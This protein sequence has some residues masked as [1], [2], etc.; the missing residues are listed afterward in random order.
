M[1]VLK[2]ITKPDITTLSLHVFPNNVSNQHFR[3]YIGSCLPFPRGSNLHGVILMQALTQYWTPLNSLE[4]TAAHSLPT[5]PHGLTQ[6]TSVMLGEHGTPPSGYTRTRRWPMKCSHVLTKFGS[7]LQTFFSWG[8]CKYSLVVSRTMLM[9]LG[10]LQGTLRPMWRFN[11]W[12][13]M[14]Q[15]GTDFIEEEVTA[16]FKHNCGSMES[17]RTLCDL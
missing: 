4:Q 5:F 10:P 8:T 7:Q 15:D 17:A 3:R 2:V 11:T 1:W 16:Y 9:G 6:W 14:D 12:H 13:L